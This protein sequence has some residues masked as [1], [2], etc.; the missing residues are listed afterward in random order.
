[1]NTKFINKIVF[2][3]LLVISLCSCKDT[4]LD[5]EPSSSIG[6]DGATATLNNF[7]Y[8][9]NGMHS[10]NYTAWQSQGYNGEH[11]INIVRDML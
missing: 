2:I 5:T 4:Y 9:L 3:S 7:D 6:E 1:M 8:I 11:S 10:Y